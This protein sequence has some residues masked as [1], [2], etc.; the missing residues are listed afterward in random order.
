[1]LR[2]LHIC[3]LVL[4]MPI[5]TYACTYILFPMIFFIIPFY[6]FE[7]VLSFNLGSLSFISYKLGDHYLS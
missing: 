4:V 3:L 1:M 6:A 2:D 5:H 7:W